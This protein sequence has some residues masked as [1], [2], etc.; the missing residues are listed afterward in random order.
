[1]VPDTWNVINDHD[2][3]VRMGK[4]MCLYKRNGHRVIIDSR[5]S[6]TVQPGPLDLHVMPGTGSLR[7]DCCGYGLNYYKACPL[8]HP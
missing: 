5:G 7:A 1:M 8:I 6:M 3:V 2:L 4:M